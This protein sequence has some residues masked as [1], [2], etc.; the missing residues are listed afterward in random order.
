MIIILF[1]TII[2]NIIIFSFG[3]VFFSFFFREK[4]SK[5]NLSEIPLFGII[6]LSFIAVTI[7]FFFPINKIIGTIILIVGLCSLI[8]ILKNNYFLVK[9]IF[10]NLLVSSFISYL[11][12]SFSNIYRPDAGLYHLPFISMI[13]DNKI[14]LGSV[15][16]NFRYAIT[17]IAQYL[18]ATQN[19]YIFDLRSISIPIASVFSFSILFMVHKFRKSLKYKNDINSFIFFLITCYSLIS[20]GRFSNYGNDSISHL[21][22]FILIIFIINH[23]QELFFDIQKFNKIALISIFLFSTKAFMLM[24]LIVPLIFLIF[25]KNLKKI[26]QNRTSYIFGLFLIVWIIRTILISGCIIY[27]LEKTCFKNLKF[28][29]HNQTVLEANSGEAWAKD[30]INQKEKVA[31]D[32]YNKDFIWLK[33]WKETHLKKIIE[34]KTPFFIFLFILFIILFYQ[35]NKVKKKINHEIIF[36]F[37]LSLIL[38][39]TWFLKFPLYRYGSSF[40]ASFAICIFIFFINLL[41]LIPN[42]YKFYKNFKI[43]IVICSFAFLSKNIIRINKNVNEFN[44]KQW[45]DIY[46]ENNDYKVNKFE[47]AHNNKE[48]LYFFSDGALCMYSKSPCS[49]YDIHNL[50]KEEKFS[51]SVFWKK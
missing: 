36:V 24:I 47:Y 19:N 2:T 49:N 35:N 46:S 51:Y 16:I 15:N 5:D 30:W 26:F 48:K 37:I 25:N 11:L 41:N 10:K 42:N 34:K 17:S 23:Y 43:F 8:V 44:N 28:Y 38:I 14:I 21:F 12:I 18:S 20:F 31:F 39:L 9:K 27:P 40:I 32:E 22:F 29:D 6:F 1:N 50:R 45:P 13:N 33:T 7:N 4:L 3:S